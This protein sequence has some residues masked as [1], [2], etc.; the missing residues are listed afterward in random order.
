M[1]YDSEFRDMYVGLQS[2]TFA[3]MTFLNTKNTLI[4]NRRYL[5]VQDAQLVELLI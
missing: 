5:K 3:S 4:Y 2:G 1:G